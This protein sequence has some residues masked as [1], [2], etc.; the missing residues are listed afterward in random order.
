MPQSQPFDTHWQTSPPIP[1]APD[2]RRK[3]SSPPN[4]LIRSLH[5]PPLPTPPSA[6]LQRR[7]RQSDVTVGGLSLKSTCKGTLQSSFFR[8]PLKRVASETDVTRR[9][10][11]VALEGAGRTL[12]LSGDTSHSGGRY[13]FDNGDDK[14]DT[15]PFAIFTPSHLNPNSSSRVPTFSSVSAPPTI[16]RPPAEPEEVPNI[17]ALTIGF[18]NLMGSSTLAGREEVEEED[19]EEGDRSVVLGS[20]PGSP[21]CKQAER[22]RVGKEVDAL[23]CSME[24]QLSF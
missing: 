12:P 6:P 9:M 4:L 1:S 14:F 16:C 22:V 21:S 20:P 18:T 11:A 7:K 10:A 15:R 8:R 24:V 13:S 19:G 3:T 23:I 17:E 2:K 5:S